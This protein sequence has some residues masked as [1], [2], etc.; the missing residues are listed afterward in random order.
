V[1]GMTLKAAKQGFF[2]RERVHKAVDKSTRK[3][4]SRFGAFVRQRARTSI[5][6]RKGTS[7]PGQPPHSHVGLLRRLIFFAYDRGQQSVVIGPTLLRQDS[8][9]PGLLEHGGEVVR[10]DKRAH[11]KLRYRPRPFMA[12]AFEQEQHRLPD[13]WHNS[14][15]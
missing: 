1:F 11:R 7:P 2:D 8:E 9:A 14:I 10:P 13:L 12:P 6:R 5:R 15:R 3:N 4:L